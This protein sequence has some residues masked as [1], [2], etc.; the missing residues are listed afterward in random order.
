MRAEN[1]LAVGPLVVADDDG[2]AAAEA[3]P[4]HRRLVGHAAGQPQRVGDGVV[5]GVVL[6]EAGAAEGGPEGGVVDGDDAEIAAGG[7][8]A[9]DHLLVAV[10]GDVLEQIHGSTHWELAV[11]G[12]ARTPGR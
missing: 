2:L 6:P 3:E 5:G 8:V 12:P 7:F 4:G 9:E 11:E 10:S 1:G